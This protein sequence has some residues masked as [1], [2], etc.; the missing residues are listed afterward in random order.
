MFPIKSVSKEFRHKN[1]WSLWETIFFNEVPAFL[2]N[3]KDLKIKPKEDT[4]F[5]I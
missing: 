2:K 5:R 4:N 1:D 3:V